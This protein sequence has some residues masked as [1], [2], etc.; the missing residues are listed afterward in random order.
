[1]VPCCENEGFLRTALTT[2]ANVQ[3]YRCKKVMKNV[4]L[5]SLNKDATNHKIM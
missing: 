3:G 1:M 2:H 5:Y 4:V